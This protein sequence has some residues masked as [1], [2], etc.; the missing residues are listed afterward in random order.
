MRQVRVRLKSR[1]DESYRIFAGIGSVD[2]LP[3]LI[4]A[5]GQGGIIALVIDA[6]AASFHEERITSL[7]DRTGRPW[8][9]YVQPSGEEHKTREAKERIED[10]LFQS[11]L[12]R[13]SLI[14]A[15][16][17][18]VTGDMAGFTAATFMRGIPV[19]QLPTTLLSQVDS[20]V[21]GKTGLDTPAGKNM[22]GAFHQPVG[23]I[24]D[25]VFL[26]TLEDDEYLSGFGEILKH[27]LLFD[28]K[29]YQLLLDKKDLLLQRDPELVS[30]VVAINCALKARVVKR[31]AKEAEYRKTLNLGHT[32][33]HALES[34]TNFRV[35]HGIAVLHG[36]CAEACIG[37][38]A[39]LLCQEVVDAVFRLV[40]AYLPEDKRW[41][42]YD[43][44]KLIAAMGFDKKN[45]D[46]SIYFSLV[47]RVGSPLKLDKKYAFAIPERLIREGIQVFKERF[48]L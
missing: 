42:E 36:L 43:P 41:R 9:K 30:G 12:G 33:A 2:K 13:S 26:K 20:S 4:R 39:G 21:G 38:V 6:N 31:D 17:G 44:D 37:S 40:E 8:V 25:P 47:D 3:E 18:G 29:L 1:V 5:S 19:I 22:V 15:A 23:V 48:L 27:A 14:V 28:R 35:K 11:G 34:V 16:G 24:T 46:A 32:F 45:R 10:F 7:L